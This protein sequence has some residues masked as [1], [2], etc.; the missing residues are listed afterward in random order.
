MLKNIV[1]LTYHRKTKNVKKELQEIT[2]I[3]S[4]SMS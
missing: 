4:M 2:S 1:A 3:L